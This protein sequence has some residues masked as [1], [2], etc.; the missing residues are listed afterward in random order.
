MTVLDVLRNFREKKYRVNEETIGFVERLGISAGVVVKLRELKQEK[1][2][3]EGE[4]LNLLREQVGKLGVQQQSRIL[5]AAA[6]ASYHAEIEFPVVRLVVCDEAPQF[7]WVTEELALCWVHDGRH[8]KKLVPY[9][10]YHREL[11][12][13]FLGRYWGFYDQL[14][15][16]REHNSVEEKVRLSLEFDEL[17]TMVTGYKEL[18][19]RIA[20]TL[21]KKEYLLRV[22]EHPEIELHNNPAELGARMRVRKRDVSFGTRSE[23][24]TKAW[25]TF[26]TVVATAKKLGVSLYKYLQ[27][28]ISEAY[29]MPSLAEVIDER[30]KVLNLGASW[31]T[32]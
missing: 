7:K 20:K 17:F 12:E 2:L 25:D 28:R 15:K 10:A 11:L 32:S 1:D 14:V 18:D 31:N 23:A 26:M 30:A 3:A 24:G 16:Y 13:E 4:F 29:Q 6:I 21:E 22:L 5:E 8:Y 9:V 27:D 19:E